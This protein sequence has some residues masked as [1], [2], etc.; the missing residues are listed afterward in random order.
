M[1]NKNISKIKILSLSILM[2]TFAFIA[3][4]LKSLANIPISSYC[5]LSIQSMQL[6]TNHLQDLIGLMNHYQADPETLAQQIAIKQAEYDQVTIDL[7]TS[8]GTTANEY[9]MYLGKYGHEVE[10]YLEANTD[11]KQQMDD[12]TVQINSLL[13]EYEALKGYGDEV[14]P[15]EPPLP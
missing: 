10:A 1:K 3:S 9:V 7:Y 4:P 6:E 5:Q 12:L 14:P 2:F 15:E 8:F 13:A 11:I